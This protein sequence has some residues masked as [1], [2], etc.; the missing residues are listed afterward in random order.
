[1]KHEFFSRAGFCIRY[2]SSTGTDLDLVL[3][4]LRPHFL[5]GP[6]VILPFWPYRCMLSSAGTLKSAPKVMPWPWR[7]D[8]D[9]HPSASVMVQNRDDWFKG[10]CD[11]SYI[12]SLG[13]RASVD[14][15]EIEMRS[16]L[17][18]FLSWDLIILAVPGVYVQLLRRSSWFRL[19]W[20]S[21]QKCNSSSI[22]ELFTI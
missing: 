8:P 6:S 5:H 7:T 14:K 17:C 19:K 3:E 1:M 18:A 4:K 21:T 10:F 9:K 12:C 22:L 13:S 11:T 16:Y 15:G 20:Q 2:E